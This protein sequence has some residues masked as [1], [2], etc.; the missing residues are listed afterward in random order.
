[1]R[2]RCRTL[3]AL[4]TLRQWPHLKDR[5][6]VDLRSASDVAPLL[7]SRLSCLVSLSPGKERTGASHFHCP[8]S[9]SPH[10]SSFPFAQANDQLLQEQLAVGLIADLKQVFEQARFQTMAAVH[11]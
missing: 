7:P 8:Q 11:R 2:T 6:R 4:T 3:G 1:M 10:S 9:V 5:R